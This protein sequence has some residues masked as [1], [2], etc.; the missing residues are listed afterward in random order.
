MSRLHGFHFVCFRKIEF[1][2]TTC[3]SNFLTDNEPNAEQKVTDDTSIQILN[4]YH[5]RNV[6]LCFVAI[7]A[8]QSFVGVQIKCWIPPEFDFHESYRDYVD[9]HCWT[10]NTFYIPFDEVI[11]TYTENREEKEII[12]YQWIKPVL[13]FLALL[14]FLPR[15][16]WQIFARYSGLD[17]SKLLN[18]TTNMKPEMGWIASYLKVWL[19]LCRQTYNRKYGFS[20]LMAELPFIG[21]YN[22]NYLT[23]L[24]SFINILYL[25]NSIGQIYILDKILSN[26]F[27]DLGFDVLR[28]IWRNQKLSLELYRFPR[29]TLCDLDIRQMT[30]VHRWTVQCSLPINLFHEKVFIAVWFLLFT[31]SVINALYLISTLVLFYVPYKRVDF[32]QK[33]LSLTDNRSSMKYED[34]ERIERFVYDYLRHDGVFVIWIFN[35]NT[36]PV[37]AIELTELLWESFSASEENNND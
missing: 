3:I 7:L 17:L 15:M 2:D 9:A 19:S 24:F 36:S 20:K 29:T 33:L 37:Y 6:I 34:T 23:C 16:L 8:M 25:A 14:F 35:K 21:R 5:C 30:N 26:N 27:R 28:N 10:E 12:Y 22:G 32:I 11:P 31:M 13:C 4:R 18:M 1:K